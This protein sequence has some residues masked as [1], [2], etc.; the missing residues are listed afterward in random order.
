M[1]IIILYLNIS[2]NVLVNNILQIIIL[3]NQDKYHKR[4]VQ[5]IQ[6]H[7]VMY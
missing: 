5:F 2:I 1:S 6:T 4:A 7:Y 3:K